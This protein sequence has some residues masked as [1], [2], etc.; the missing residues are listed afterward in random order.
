MFTHVI[1]RKPTTIQP[2]SSLTQKSRQRCNWVNTRLCIRQISQ[3][4][5]QSMNSQTHNSILSQIHVRVFKWYLYVSWYG[6]FQVS[7]HQGLS[8]LLLAAV[9]RFICVALRL[10]ALIVSVILLFTLKC[11]TF[12]SLKAI[13]WKGARKYVNVTESWFKC[14]V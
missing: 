1:K 6:C 12:K 5:S 3:I 10:W 11:Y 8:L 2:T 13:S 14:F 9:F 4:I 7:L